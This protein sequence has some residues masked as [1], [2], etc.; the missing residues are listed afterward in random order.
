M[1]GYESENSVRERKLLQ[2]YQLKQ[3]ILI[4]LY[5]V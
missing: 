5:N 4:T 1:V 2:L 3:P